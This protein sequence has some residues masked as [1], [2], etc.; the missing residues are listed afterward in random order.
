MIF[1][2]SMS[3]HKSTVHSQLNYIFHDH[4]T[5]DHPNDTM[6]SS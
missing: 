4:N 5:P 3:D 6:P 2:D 1:L